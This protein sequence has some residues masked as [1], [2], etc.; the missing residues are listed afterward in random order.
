[1]LHNENL[2][3][4]L[5]ATFE[6]GLVYEFVPGITLTTNTVSLPSI[7]RLVAREMAKLHLVKASVETAPKPMIWD[8]LDQF[9]NLI[10]DTFTE[11]HVQKK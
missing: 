11:S 3:P 4:Q 1:M 8:K 7:F 6:N 9:Y 10:P 5:Y 2:A